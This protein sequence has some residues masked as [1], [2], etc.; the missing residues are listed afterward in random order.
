MRKLNF[1]FGEPAGSVNMFTKPNRETTH[2]CENIFV[3]GVWNK[4][5]VSFDG[6]T[7]LVHTDI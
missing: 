4:Y 6:L 1:S 5:G 3:I 7:E 2:V